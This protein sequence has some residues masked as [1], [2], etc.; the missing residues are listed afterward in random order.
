MRF[1]ES[2][3]A[4]IVA[5]F[6]PMI[7]LL[8]YDGVRSKHPGSFFAIAVVGALI[9]LYYFLSLH[10]K[11]ISWYKSG[12]VGFAGIFVLGIFFLVRAL[13]AVWFPNMVSF[14]N[15]EWLVSGSAA[16]LAFLTL[17]HLTYQTS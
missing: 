13:V 4:A 15:Y 10:Y 5:S 12:K 16:F 8:L 7:L 9:G 17:F 11:K 3:E 14:V 6:A 1:Y 2:L